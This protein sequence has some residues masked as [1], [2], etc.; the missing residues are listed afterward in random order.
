MF[1]SA[2]A[3]GTEPGLPDTVAPA[4]DGSLGGMEDVD[5][6]AKVW[7]A[8]LCCAFPMLQ[9]GPASS[10]LSKAIFAVS[11][12]LGLSLLVPEPFL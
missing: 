6:P 5:G 3:H 12:L 2:S 1:P 8:D 10:C 11:T 9:G 4:K 7:K